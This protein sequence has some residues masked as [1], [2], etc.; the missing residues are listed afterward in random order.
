MTSIVCLLGSC[1]KFRFSKPERTKSSTYPGIT[2][3]ST[4]LTYVYE[5]TLVQFTLVGNI[6]EVLQSL[7]HAWE[8]IEEVADGELLK[9]VDAGKKPNF[10]NFEESL[11]PSEKILEKSRVNGADIWQIVS[12]YLLN[13]QF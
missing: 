3:F 8:A 6:W 11:V 12:S 9:T 1:P 10:N 5:I 13:L 2:V 4:F 7:V